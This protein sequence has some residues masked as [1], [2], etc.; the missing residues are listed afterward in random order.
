MNITLPSVLSFDRNEASFTRWLSP[1]ESVEEDCPSLI[2]PSPTSCRGRSRSMIR[3]QVAFFLIIAEEGDRVVHRH[4]QYVVDRFLAVA[5]SRISSLKRL[6]P[7][8]SHTSSTSAMNCMP[9]LDESLALTLLATAAGDVEREVRGVESRPLG[10]GL[11]GVEFADFV[12]GLDVGHGVRPRG[13]ADRVLIDHFDRTKRR[14]I[15]FDGV[16]IARFEP[17]SNSRRAMRD[18]GVPLASDDFAAC[19]LRP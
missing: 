2:Y 8:A 17:V 14:K 19:R 4:L 16:E 12:V 3:L 9:T 10:V 6:P 5:D 1:P 15:A 13:F 7:Q 11:V 18:R